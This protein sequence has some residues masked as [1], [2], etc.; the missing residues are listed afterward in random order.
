MAVTDLSLQLPASFASLNQGFGF[1]HYSTVLPGSGGVAPGSW[2]ALA[3]MQVFDSCLT[4]GFSSLVVVTAG[5]CSYLFKRP[6]GWLAGL[7]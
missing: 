6:V 2:L 7:V 4:F 1:V 5:S 3:A